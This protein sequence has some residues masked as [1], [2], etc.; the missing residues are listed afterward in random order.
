MRSLS[1]DNSGCSMYDVVVATQT[2]WPRTTM[3]T[4]AMTYILCWS[5]RA[6][7]PY[8]T[9]TTPRLRLSF[10]SQHPNYLSNTPKAHSDAPQDDSIGG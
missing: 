10:T 5:P 3:T 8:S 7:S 6:L 4:A 2:S 1:D 9:A